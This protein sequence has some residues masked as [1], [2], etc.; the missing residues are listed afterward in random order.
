LWGKFWGKF[1]GKFSPQKC[2]EKLEFSVEKVS[3]IVFPRNF[4]GIFRRKSL[5]AEKN[6]RKIGP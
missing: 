3:K 5:S 1:R 6:V 4:T 2:W